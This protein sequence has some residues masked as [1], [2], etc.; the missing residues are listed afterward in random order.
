[1]ANPCNTNGLIESIPSSGLMI[2]VFSEIK[3]QFMCLGCY[4]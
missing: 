3:G 4:L 2:A 1:M